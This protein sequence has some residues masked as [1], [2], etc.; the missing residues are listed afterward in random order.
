MVH[1]ATSL[2]RH[3]RIHAVTESSYPSRRQRIALAVLIGVVSLAMSLGL[4]LGRQRADAN[5]KEGADFRVPLDAAQ[6]V[7]TRS[8]PYAAVRAQATPED[9]GAAFY[10]P[11]PAALVAV[12]FTPFPRWLAGAVFFGLSSGLL[13]WLITRRSYDQ[14]PLFFS[15]PFIF[16]AAAAQ[17]SPFLIAVSFVPALSGFLI[18]KPN[19]GA[20]LFLSRPTWQGIAGAL[21][22]AAVSFLILPSWLGDW[23]GTFDGNGTVF[24]RPPILFSFFGPVLLLAALRWRR[25]EGRLLLLMACMPQF[26]FFYDQLLLWLVP[27]SRREALNLS[28]FSFAAFAA[29]MAFSFDWTTR[30]VHM[31]S[32]A[33]YVLALLYIPCLVMVLRRPNEA[34]AGLLPVAQA[35]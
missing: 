3:A 29:W 27:Q 9:P 8:N 13:A 12:P 5:V 26:P 25:P 28:W 21:V 34:P 30:E 24:H 23:L 32:A 4:T 31:A 6:A 22:L 14:L 18:V 11:L 7:L 19:L 17:W 20:A 33:P 1:Q 2:S 35:A 10:Y 16:A 15:T